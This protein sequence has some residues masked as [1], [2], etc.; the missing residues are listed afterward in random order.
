MLNFCRNRNTRETLFTAL[1]SRATWAPFDNTL[2][3]QR[4]LQLR[5]EL[6]RLLG[7]QSYAELSMQDKMAP[8]VA[9]V[10]ALVHDLRD[11]CHAPAQAELDDLTAF[12]VQHGQTARLEH[13]DIEFWYLRC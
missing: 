9:A 7:F 12:A 4:I 1:A 2:I 3:I 6:A 13:W 10:E 11:K 5:A 8:S